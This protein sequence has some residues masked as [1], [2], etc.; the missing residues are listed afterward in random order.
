[1]QLCVLVSVN[2]KL[3]FLTTVY[4]IWRNWRKVKATI[5]LWRSRIAKTGFRWRLNFCR[6]ISRWPWPRRSS[7]SANLFNF[8]SANE[9]SS[10]T[11]Q[12]SK[13]KRRSFTVSWWD[14]ILSKMSECDINVN[15]EFG[16]CHLYLCTLRA[17]FL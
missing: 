13:T 6:A 11:E 16:F 9:G 10:H 3:F 2:N 15:L 1:M 8:L 14:S 17:R 7:S 12:S 4:L 5:Q